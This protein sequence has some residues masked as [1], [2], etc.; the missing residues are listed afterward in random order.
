MEKKE[1]KYFREHFEELV[2][3]YGGNYIAIIGE[4]IVT[5]N[6]SAKK[7]EEDAILKFPDSKPIVAPIP[8]KEDLVC[9]L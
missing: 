6:K 9:A 2:D 5:V 1:I 7:A 3:K 8:K 4:N